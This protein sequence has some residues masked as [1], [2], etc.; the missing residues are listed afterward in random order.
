MGRHGKLIQELIL[1]EKEDETF[2]K[3]CPN[4]P[5]GNLMWDDL[6][7]ATSQDDLYLPWH[8]R[9]LAREQSLPPIEY[10]DMLTARKKGRLSIEAWTPT[11]EKCHDLWFTYQQAH[12][13]NK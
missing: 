1:E 4:E 2:T 10:R 5:I 3:P 9:N 6:L 8:G 13:S 7:W 11:T 12:L